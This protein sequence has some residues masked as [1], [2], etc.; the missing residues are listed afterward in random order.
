MTK[1]M[2]ETIRNREQEKVDALKAKGALIG[3]PVVE[4]VETD[5]PT[6]ELV[7]GNFTWRNRLTP[8]P[9]FKSGKM[10]IAYT[11]EGFETEYGGE[12]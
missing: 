1:A 4:F 11:T 8:T 3:E 5:N 10:K 12:E 6:E 9:P 7:E 2:A